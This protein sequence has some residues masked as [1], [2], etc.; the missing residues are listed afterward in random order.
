MNDREIEMIPLLYKDGGLQ[1]NTGMDMFILQGTCVGGS[2]TLSN[3]VMMRAP[4]DVLAS[5]TRFGAELDPESL[6]RSYE[7]IEREIG[8]HRGGRCAYV[9][10]YAPLHR[11]RALARAF[12][13]ANAQSARRLPRVR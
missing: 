1:M 4:G 13:A 7:T 9:R 6:L 12:A 8:G 11:R 10:E 3:M 5:W 2:T